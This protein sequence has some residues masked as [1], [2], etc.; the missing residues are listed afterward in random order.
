MEELSCVAVEGGREAAKVVA[1]ANLRCFTRAYYILPVLS[2]WS[3][4]D[5]F[6]CMQP[7]AQM[8]QVGVAARLGLCDLFA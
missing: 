2:L 5:Y 4:S 7:A 1:D 3:T 6:P 8:L